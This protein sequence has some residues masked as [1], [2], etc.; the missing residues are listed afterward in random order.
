MIASRRHRLHRIHRAPPNKTNCSI[1]KNAFETSNVHIYCP[2]QYCCRH[3]HGTPPPHQTNWM[4]CYKQ[5]YRP[6]TFYPVPCAMH[7]SSR[8]SFAS[9]WTGIIRAIVP[10]VRCCSV[11]AG[12]P[13]RT[14][15]ETT[16][17]LS[18]RCNGRK[19]RR[20]ARRAD[21]LVVHPNT[22]DRIIE[23]AFA[24]SILIVAQWLLY[25]VRQSLHFY[26]FG[27][28]IFLNLW[29]FFFEQ[30]RNHTKPKNILDIRKPLFLFPKQ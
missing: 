7:R 6:D 14:R 10:F 27:H 19:W 4:K 26:V 2:H 11:A 5:P 17:E 21:H 13:I 24:W 30:K 3:V 25:V 12:L 15:C 20:C 28:N 18:T 16:C 29:W 23:N 1:T 8:A 22:N 9:I